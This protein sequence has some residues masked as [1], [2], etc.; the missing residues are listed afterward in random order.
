MSD[1]VKVNGRPKLLYEY[2]LLSRGVVQ[3]DGDGAVGEDAV[4]H[5]LAAVLSVVDSKGPHKGGFLQL[6]RGKV[7]NVVHGVKI[8]LLFVSLCQ[9][10][11][12][13]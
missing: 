7:T 6:A 1:G 4:P 2:E 3:D 10:L 8:G 9:T 5:L 11:I 12:G 13:E